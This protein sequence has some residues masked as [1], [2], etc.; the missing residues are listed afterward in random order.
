MVNTYP[1]FIAASQ[2]TQ[3]IQ[4]RSIVER[5]PEAEKQKKIRAVQKKL[6]DIR[7]LKDKLKTGAALEKNQEDKIHN[8]DKLVQE[9]ELLKTS[10]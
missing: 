5:S 8:E 4:G 2:Q 6:D 10:S 3:N 1:F 9:L 7:K